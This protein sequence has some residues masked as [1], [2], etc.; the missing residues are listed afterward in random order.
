MVKF[1]QYYNNCFLVNNM[2]INEIFIMLNNDE[3][4]L[5]ISI[6][7]HFNAGIHYFS[8]YLKPDLN[9]NFA[10]SF[11]SYVGPLLCVIIIKHVIPLG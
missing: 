1:N 7:Q 8:I 11:V 6:F 5:F 10:R 2:G 3:N 4:D 9:F